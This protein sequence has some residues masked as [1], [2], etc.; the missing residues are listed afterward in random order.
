MTRVVLINPPSYVVDNP[1]PPLGLL[2]IASYVQEHVVGVT[3]EI[4]DLERLRLDEALRRVDSSCWDGVVLIGLTVMSMDVPK[5]CEV[6]ERAREHAPGAL[7]IAGGPHA[8]LAWRDFLS[9]HSPPFDA[10]VVGEGE[11]ATVR[12]LAALAAGSDLGSIPG[13]A[14]CGVD[15][16]PRLAAPAALI[17]PA[18]WANPFRV[19][20]H[21]GTDEPM[22][23][24]EQ[25]G[26]RRRGVSLVTSR[27]CALACTFCAIAAM[28]EPYRSAEPEAVVAWLQWE[29]E[30]RRFEHI[31]FLDADFLTSK[32]RA[33]AFSEAVHN[34]FPDVTWSVQAT[35]GH[36]LSLKDDLARLHERGLRAVELGIEAGDDDQLLFFNK[37]NFGKPATV[38][39][40]IDAVELL[41]RHRLIVGIDYIM[42]YPDQTLVGLARNVAF[43][44]RSGL[45]DAFSVSHYGHELILFPGTPV[46]SLYESRCEHQW[47]T[48]TLPATDPLF[49]DRD[50]LAVKNE[51]T[52]VY[53][54]RFADRSQRLREALRSAARATGRPRVRAVLRLHEM[55]IRHHPYVVLS[56]LV[57][58]RGDG[59]EIYPRI[60]DDLHAATE[61]LHS[62]DLSPGR[63]R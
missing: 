35:V 52:G 42:F 10:C 61:A 59:G 5:A 40:S 55:R 25:G 17:Q 4:L 58:S 47:Q 36:V 51:F 46:R 33:R 63:A 30:R 53:L 39:Q 32:A 24:V 27:S 2:A 1:V 29:Y 54:P 21:T 11:R 41:T 44:L 38:Q 56:G 48:D 7:V 62:A 9:R 45:I 20:R 8:T 60:E 28:E 37:R 26:R 13:V 49:R 50:V 19:D 12:V 3:C 6:A 14:Q 31:Y 23:F 22:Y 43:F 34:A 16:V 18:E 57:Q 15:G